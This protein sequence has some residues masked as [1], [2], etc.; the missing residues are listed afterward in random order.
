[1]TQPIWR[2]SP[3]RIARAQLTRFLA[4]VRARRP[5]GADEITDF[6]SLYTWSVERPDG[7]WPE[8]WRYCGV[9]ADERVG[10]DP[11][12]RVVVGLERMAPP[13]PQLGPRW[14]PGARLNFAENLLRYGDEREALVF[15]N[16]QGRGKRLTYADLRHEVA[17]AAAALRAAGV[18]IGDRVA[19]FLPNLPE[20]VVAMLPRFRGQRRAR[21][22]RPDPA[23]SAGLRRRLPLRGKSG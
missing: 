11:W 6:P 1:M 7:F 22:I 9:V 21:P 18:G 13:D 10:R 12:D 23:E 19:G 14:F 2:P 8:V 4:H 15:W 3:D 20:T 16:E 17:A 5:A